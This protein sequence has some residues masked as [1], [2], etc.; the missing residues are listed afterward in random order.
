V[1]AE[2]D[3]LAS[4]ERAVEV[5]ALTHLQRELGARGLLLAADRLAAAAADAA[6]R[7]SELLASVIAWCYPELP[8]VARSVEFDGA[9]TESAIEVALACGAASA[10]VL[11]ASGGSRPGELASATFNLGI[12]LIDGLCDEDAKTG[13]AVVDVLHGQDLAG[14]AAARRDRGWLQLELA[15]SFGGDPTVMFTATVVEAFF[16]MLH[17]GYD[18][19]ARRR[20]GELLEAALDA[21]RRSI[22][23]LAHDRPPDQLAVTSRLTSVLPFEIVDA[24]VGAEPD[25]HAGTQ[26]GEAMWRIDDLVDLCHDARSGALNAVLLATG[27]RERADALNRLLVSTDIADAA[28]EAAEKLSAALSLGGTG[29]ETLLALVHRYVAIPPR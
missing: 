28:R 14:A 20:L 15:S 3:D 6:R 22:A 18:E 25:S 29:R 8:G 7:G 4:L 24:L 13:R 1:A 16:E 26:L 21:E 27:T 9:G 11:G 5:A 19:T 2:P 12:G 10:A 17:G 23:P